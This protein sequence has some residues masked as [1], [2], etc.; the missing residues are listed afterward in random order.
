VSS[1][2]PS[3]RRTI[4]YAWVAV[5]VLAATV[6]WMFQTQFM[7]RYL[8]LQD[9]DVL[10]FRQAAEAVRD[11]L[12]LYDL[13][14]GEVGGWTWPPFGAIAVL[15]TL[16]VP[17]DLLLPV[18]YAVSIACLVAVV[19][20][21]A[22]PL[23][24]RA[25]DRTGRTLALIGLTLLAIPLTPV[26]DTL[27][28]GQIGLVLLLLVALDLVV[29]ARRAPRWHGVL[30]G[31][32]TAVKVTPGLFVVHLLVTRQWRAAA[33]A[34][35]TTLLCWLLA[36]AVLWRDSADYWGRGLLLAV[37]DRVDGFG[38]WVYNQSWMGLV[39]GLPSPWPIVLWLLLSAAT[40]VVALIA[41]ARAHAAGDP[42]MVL[43]LVGLASVLVT[44]IAW[45]HHAVWVV[46]ALLAVVGDG[47]TRWRNAGAG[48]VAVLLMIPSRL[49]TLPPD[50]YVVEY[51]AL[52]IL[53]LAVARRGSVAA[54]EISASPSPREDRAA[55]G[56]P[57]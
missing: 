19:A 11:G 51:V 57:R 23:L 2:A 47:R 1:S 25:P 8:A 42:V 28:L 30:I 18:S 17:L 49:P 53:M 44:P 40:A 56:P 4:A 39:D 14:F 3:T 31:V 24:D 13:R 55:P 6:G 50:R 48:V 35:G 27:G 36:A 5:L 20:L 15:P 7:W 21:C 41:S 29:V 52:L 10:I 33:T 38:S 54:E 45:H 37:N 26:A 32:A 46:P 34:V 43:G 9:S 22:R 12:P 16:L